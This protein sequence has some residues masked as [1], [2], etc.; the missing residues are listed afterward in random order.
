MECPNCELPRYI[1]CSD[2]VYVKV[3]KYF[4]IIQCFQR[5][6]RCLEIAKLLMSHASSVFPDGLMRS[7]VEN[8]Q[9]ASVHA[10]DSGFTEK[11]I[12]LYA[13]MVVDGTNPFGNQNTRHSTWP[14]LIVLYNLP[15]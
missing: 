1:T 9:W 5:L 2:K 15:P 11:D 12:N 6:F 3:F 7:I 14:L 10:F 4:P 8:K 13:S